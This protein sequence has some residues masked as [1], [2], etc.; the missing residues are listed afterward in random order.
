M[1]IKTTLGC[2]ITD[3]RTFGR[4]GSLL[5][6]SRSSWSTY[7]VR[8]ADYSGERV[9]PVQWGV[10]RAR[11]EIACMNQSVENLEIEI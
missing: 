4:Q 2:Q 5:T 10:N 1:I 9:T 11:T 7:Q 8:W 6:R 3:E